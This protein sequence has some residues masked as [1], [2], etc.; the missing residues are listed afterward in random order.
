MSRYISYLILLCFL[1]LGCNQPGKKQLYSEPLQLRFNLNT[2]SS[3]RYSIKSN[4]SLTQELENDKSISINQNTTMMSALKIS[5]HQSKSVNVDVTYERIT[6]SSGNQ[7]FSLDYDS[8]HDNGTDP[9]YEDLRKLIDKT[10]TITLSENGEVLS[11]EAIV[12][13]DNESYMPVGVLNDSSIRK[14]MVHALSFYP[15]QA[16]STGDIWERTY[17]TSVGFA[18]V[19]VKNKYQLVSIEGDIAHLELQ[20]L[21]SSEYSKQAQN[22]NVQLKGTQS[23]ELDVIIP[24]GV[25]RSGKITQTLSGS[26]NITGESTPVDVESSIFIIG[27]TKRQMVPN[28]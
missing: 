8:E 18:N 3:Y 25:V 22:S 5:S 15:K 7:L 9:M 14:I 13:N 17:N 12:D 4:V 21:L 26:M 16:I 6:M 1:C 19:K 23:G 24:T 28:K 11:S 20:G 10:F 2:D 27:T